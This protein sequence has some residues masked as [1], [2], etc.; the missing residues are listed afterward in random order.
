MRVGGQVTEPTALE[1]FLTARWGMHTA[2]FGRSLYLPNS[3]PRWPLHRAELL[4]CDEGLVAAA[5][6]PA[7]TGPP[8]SVLWSPGVPVRFG[9][10]PRRPAG[11]PTP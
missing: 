5:G 9:P 3:H 1:H 11:I 10:P 8:A 6:L 4:R 7:P 2:F